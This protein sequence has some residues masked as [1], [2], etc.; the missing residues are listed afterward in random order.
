MYGLDS[1][2][3]LSPAGTG[4]FWA[5]VDPVA[6][7]PRHDSPEGTIYEVVAPYTTDMRRALIQVTNL[8]I[9]VK[10]SPQSTLVF[11]TRLD[12]AAPVPDARVAIVDTSNR[13]R[14]RGTTDRDGV[15]LAP[16]LG[17]RSADGYG[18][19]FVVTAESGTDFAF[20]ASNWTERLGISANVL[21]GSVFTDRGVYRERD[22]VRFKAVVRVD[23]PASKALLPPDTAL[24]VVVHDGRSREIDRRTV[25]VN[26]WSSC[27]VG[28]GT[29]RTGPR[30]VTTKSACLASPHQVTHGSDV[31]GSFL[32]AAYRQP[33]FRVDTTLSGDPPVLGST[34]RGTV[35]AKYLFGAALGGRPVRWSISRTPI[36]AAPAGV[37]DRYPESR[38][39]VGYLP[40]AEEPSRPAVSHFGEERHPRRRW[41]SERSV[42]DSLRRRLCLLVHARGRCRGRLWLAHRQPRHGRGA[43]G[44]DLCRGV[45][46]AD[47]RRHEDRRKCLVRRGRSVRKDRAWRFRRGVPQAVAVVAARFRPVQ[48]RA[49]GNAVRSTLGSGHSLRPTA[50]L[51]SR[52]LSATAAVTSCERSRATRAGR[53]TS[54]RRG[55]LRAGAGR[56]DVAKR[57]KAHRPD[58]GARDVEARRDGANPGAF[59]VG[60]GDRPRHRRARRH[61]ESSHVHGFVNTGGHRGTDH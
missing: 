43:P 21:R 28:H 6:F 61:P 42:A 20:V 49:S 35:D 25:R 2:H 19:S 22:T 44:V 10:D 32:V 36:L 50:K 57:R 46:A 9:S 12:T 41:T 55:L 45:T 27:G 47:V 31:R 18:L 24:E 7:L 38:Y 23:T 40:D 17:L 13:T 60:A 1:R 4:L 16:A 51:R 56:V 26:R 54:H 48:A 52:F 3:L 33:D 5:A 39:A 34:L 58:T 53:Q 14:W 30:S 11:V 59:T 29:C 15:A 37:R 8:G